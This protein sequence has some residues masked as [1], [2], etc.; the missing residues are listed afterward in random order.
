MY[1]RFVTYLNT[2]VS[3]IAR[4]DS[5]FALILN[6][7]LPMDFCRG[8]SAEEFLLE[9]LRQRIYSEIS[10][11]RK[12]PK[13]LRRRISAKQLLPKSFYRTVTSRKFLA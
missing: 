11:P 13:D 6:K 3:Y 7:F 8:I 5:V 10:A 1:F 4:I 12:A 2:L 9:N